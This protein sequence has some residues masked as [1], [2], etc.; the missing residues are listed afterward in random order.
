MKATLILILFFVS[1]YYS[2]AQTIYRTVE[3]NIVITGEYKGLRVVA[4]SSGLNFFLN[5]TTKEFVGKIDLKMLKTGVAF[6]DSLIL[7]KKDSL[8]VNF[9]GTIP[10]DDFIA[11]DHPLL[12]LNVP[13]TVNANN[14]QRQ[15]VLIATIEHSKTS[16]TYACRLYGFAGLNISQFN[17]GIAGL[18]DSINVQFDQVVLKRQN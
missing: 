14:I 9:S 7:T 17:F 15:L 1:G 6:L 16:G 11:W 8:W 2:Q 12:K 10:D 4:Q 3:G 18:N 13:I 5:Y